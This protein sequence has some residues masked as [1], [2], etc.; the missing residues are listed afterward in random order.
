MLRSGEKLRD[1]DTKFM[2]KNFALP[3]VR[4]MYC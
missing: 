2:V 1:M 3:H 4:I